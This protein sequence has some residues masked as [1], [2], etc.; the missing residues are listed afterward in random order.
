M[1][2]AVHFICRESLFWHLWYFGFFSHLLYL[3]FYS[4]SSF[5]LSLA[6]F[7]PSFFL[8]SHFHSLL[9]L[10]NSFH[11]SLL[12][13]FHSCL[14]LLTFHFL[15]TSFHSSHSFVSVLYFFTLPTTLSCPS[16]ILSSF[17]FLFL[18]LPH[19]SPS[20]FLQLPAYKPPLLHIFPPLF[21][22][23]SC[24]PPLNYPP[25]SSHLCS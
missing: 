10:L 18:L 16:H 4:L 6:V 14:I 17:P 20:N 13:F 8:S 21:S 15:C 24:L 19:P 5:Y 7:S 9:P 12:P 22:L 23:P 25:P 3:V 2:C 11:R 1:R